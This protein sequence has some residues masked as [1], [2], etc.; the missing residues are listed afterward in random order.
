[1]LGFA[2]GSLVFAIFATEGF[3]KLLLI[4]LALL[5]PFLN[6]LVIGIKSVEAV[7]MYKRVKPKDLTEGDWIADDVFVKGKRICGPKDLG[8]EK[9]QIRQLIK[10]R[11]KSVVIRIGIP[12]VP[13]FLIAFLIT[14]WIGNPLGFLL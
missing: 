1:M 7:C 3:F 11:V 4:F 13:S 9:K 6:Y 8:I 12:F 2:L 5:I 14:L 10:S